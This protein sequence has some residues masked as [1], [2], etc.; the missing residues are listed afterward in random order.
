MIYH[1]FSNFP[2]FDTPE[3][4]LGPLREICAQ[5]HFYPNT[6][7]IFQTRPNGRNFSLFLR[8]LRTCQNIHMAVYSY[9]PSSILK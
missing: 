6:S 9:S 3:S 8:N 2:Q 4:R 7:S 5:V 1:F